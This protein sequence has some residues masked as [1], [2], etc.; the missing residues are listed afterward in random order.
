MKRL[1]RICSLFALLALLA[2]PSC[3]TK[4]RCDAYSGVQIE[5]EHS[6]KKTPEVRR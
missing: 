3:K 2:L 1:F 5:A 6:G 4:K